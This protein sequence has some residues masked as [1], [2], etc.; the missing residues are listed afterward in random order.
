LT[1]RSPWHR[2]DE[3]IRLVSRKSLAARQR[4]Q[5]AEISSSR[6]AQIRDTSGLGDPRVR[7]QRLDQVADL[8]GT[9]AVQVGL[10]H[11]ANSALVDPPPAFQQAG[12][13]RSGTQL[14]DTQ[15]QTPASAVCV[16]GR[17]PSRCAILVSLRSCAATSITAV[18]STSINAW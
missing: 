11:T 14:G 13:Q 7:A 8:A 9:D 1:H 18:N 4:S 5:N 10:H 2:I 3:T 17:Y 16:R 12:E 6:S 15:L